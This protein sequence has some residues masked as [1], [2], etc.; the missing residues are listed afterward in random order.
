[1][2]NGIGTV[3]YVKLCWNSTVYSTVLEWHCMFN[4]VYQYRMFNGV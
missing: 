4:G 3:P 2:F 1:M